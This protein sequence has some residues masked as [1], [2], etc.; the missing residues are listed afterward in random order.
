M[1]PALMQLQVTRLRT[2]RNLL[3]DALE[4]IVDRIENHGADAA[5]ALWRAKGAL[6]ERRGVAQ[7]LLPLEHNL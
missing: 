2:E 1:S 4:M 5:E 3:L 6:T 7:V